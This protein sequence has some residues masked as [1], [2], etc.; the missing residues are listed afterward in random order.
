MNIPDS[1]SHYITR[2]MPPDGWCSPEKA[3]ALARAV[4]E[5]RPACC[6]EIGVYSGRSLFAIALALKALGYGMAI[7]IDPWSQQASIEGWADENRKWWGALDHNA[8][9]QQFLHYRTK[10]G[11]DQTIIAMPVTSDE[12]LRLFTLFGAGV[13]IGLLHIDG[14]HSSKQALADVNGYTPMVPPGGIIVFDDLDWGTTKPAQERLA[15]ICEPITT[16]GNCGFYR[17]R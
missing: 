6:V 3:E 16:V 17:K 1:I 8:I 15:Q 2:G 9:Y 4:L 5:T 7:G 13:Q 14:N 12:A 11:L 10:L